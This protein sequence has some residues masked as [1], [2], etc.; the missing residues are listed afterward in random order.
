[1][2]TPG[3]V[4]QDHS[5]G[6]FRVRHRRT[7]SRCETG[8]T[9]PCVVDG[10]HDVGGAGVEGF[11]EAVPV[12]ESSGVVPRGAG[13][14]RGLGGW[15]SVD[16]AGVHYPFTS[17]PAGWRC[18]HRTRRCGR[19]RVRGDRPP[20]GRR[21]AAADHRTRRTTARLGALAIDGGEQLAQDCRAAR[22]REC[23]QRV[24]SRLAVDARARQQCLVDGRAAL[25]PRSTLA[26][27]GAQARRRGRP[28]CPSRTSRP[29]SVPASR[30]APAW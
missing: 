18:R 30:P 26:A 3:A 17:A 23:R 1:M 13:V 7:Q 27:R 6:S 9:V 2:A 21:G 28:G 11:E 14:G 12:D 20:A 15:P 19:R 4:L 10:C 8:D 16:V 24:A 5:R 29:T 25:D 22:C